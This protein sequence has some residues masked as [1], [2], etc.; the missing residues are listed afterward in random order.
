MENRVFRNEIVYICIYR[1]VY[2]ISFVLF[3]VMPPVCL[4][5]LRVFFSLSLCW[6]LSM[7]GMVYSASSLAIS[8][9]HQLTVPAMPASSP[10]CLPA[11]CLRV[12]EFSHHGINQFFCFILFII[13][14]QSL[15]TGCQSFLLTLKVFSDFTWVNGATGFFCYF[16]LCFYFF[17]CTQFTKL[18]QGVEKRSI[19]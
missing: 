15:K 9:A 2:N 19:Y 7:L 18:T 5:L 6:F 10:A 1:I 12:K 16:F 13:L 17:Q 4:A 11:C 8:I 14:Y 3:R